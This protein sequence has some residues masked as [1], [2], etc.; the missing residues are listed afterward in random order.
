MIF[1]AGNRWRYHKSKYCDILLYGFCSTAAVLNTVA[2][3]DYITTTFHRGHFDVSQKEKKKSSWFSFSF[4]V[5]FVA[6]WD[7]WIGQSC[8]LG[9]LSTLVSK[10]L[11]WKMYL[12]SGNHSMK[13]NAPDVL[14]DPLTPFTLN[15]IRAFFYD[16]W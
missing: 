14:A 10:C 5:T 8:C 11:L 4:I 13:I 2:A 15:I 7:T 3:C 6:Y 12:H 16:E 1:G 9:F